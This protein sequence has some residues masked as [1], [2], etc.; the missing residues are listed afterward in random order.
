M[1]GWTARFG[2][3]ISMLMSSNSP[4]MASLG[5]WRAFWRN[6][7]LLLLTMRQGVLVG[8]DDLGNAYFQ[9][10]KA[11]ISGRKRRWVQYAGAV[12][13]SAVGPEWNAWLHHLTDQPLPMT[14]RK[15]W[16]KPHEPNLTGTASSYRP[17][18]HD[19][20][21]GQRPRASGDYEAWTPDH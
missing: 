8:R 11:G 2:S 5:G 7:G 6:P 15:P 10:R 14:G 16:Q 12:E 18:G 19:Y 4:S 21:G 20:K 17:P 1:D 13:A 3:L 9:S